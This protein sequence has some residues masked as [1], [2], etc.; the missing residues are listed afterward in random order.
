MKVKVYKEIFDKK[1]IFEINLINEE[2]LPVILKMITEN[3][4]VYE[5]VC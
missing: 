1:S 2:M 4:F 3:N 5:I